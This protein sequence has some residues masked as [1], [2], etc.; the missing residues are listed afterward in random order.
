MPIYLSLFLYYKS[1]SFFLHYKTSHHSVILHELFTAQYLSFSQ[2]TQSY[3]TL[4]HAMTTGHSTEPQVPGRTTLPQRQL[5][6]VSARQLSSISAREM[7]PNWF[8]ALY[9]PQPPGKLSQKD[10]LA[11]LMNHAHWESFLQSASLSKALHPD[12]V[13]PGAVEIEKDR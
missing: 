4:E 6:I 3:T 1:S 11:L 8:A 9:V 12:G 13:G 7:G 5:R 10:P 2:F